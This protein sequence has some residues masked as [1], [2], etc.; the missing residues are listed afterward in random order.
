MPLL[1]PTRA[2]LVFLQ[3]NPLVRSRIAA[4]PG[5][6]LLY[7]GYNFQPVWKE[8]EQLKGSRPE[9]ASKQMLPDVLAGIATP[10]Q[11]Q[12]TLLA[13]AKALDALQPWHENGFIAWRAL[14]GI[15]AANAQGRVSFYVGD[16]VTRKDKVFA[17]TELPVVLRN[18]NI[19]ALTRDVLCYY[20]RCVQTGQP[21]MN[22]G[23]IAG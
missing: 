20:Q 21:A 19:D 7:A 12:P 8:L 4:R 3:K 9:V 18:P 11:P 15:F 1:Q 2:L 10:G 16:G 22:F 14:S 5:A 6:T 23:F 13:W 17:A